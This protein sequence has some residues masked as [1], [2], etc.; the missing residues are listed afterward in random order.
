MNFFILARSISPSTACVCVSALTCRVI[1]CLASILAK[2]EILGKHKGWT[3]RR[4]NDVVGCGFCSSSCGLFTAGKFL[5]KD[6]HRAGCWIFVSSRLAWSTEWVPEQPGLHTKTCLGGGYWKYPSQWES[7]LGPLLELLE[8]SS[9][10]LFSLG[11]V[12]SPAI[13]LST[14]Y[15][16]Y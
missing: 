1:T 10:S 11:T 3:D 5:P 15:W 13:K 7:I 14:H 9:F 4:N 12:K 16:F 6:G 8:K 2:E